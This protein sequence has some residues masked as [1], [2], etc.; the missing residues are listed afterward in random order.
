MAICRLILVI[1]CICTGCAVKLPPVAPDDA[2]GGRTLRLLAFDPAEAGALTHALVA[3]PPIAEH[4]IPKLAEPGCHP[5][6]LDATGGAPL[7]AAEVVAAWEAGLRDDDGP[8][9]WLLQPVV[10]ATEVSLGVADRVAGLETD[11]DALVVC[12]EQATPDWPSRLQHPALWPVVGDPGTSGARGG[13]AF[14]WSDDGRGLERATAEPRRNRVRRIVLDSASIDDDL[15]ASATGAFDLA[16]SW[17]RAAGRLLAGRDERLRLQRIPRWDT[18]YALWLVADRR[19]TN[20]PSFRRWVSTG[21]DRESMA[22]YLY[23]EQA[24]AA[25][26]LTDQDGET[27]ET[28]RRP[29]SAASSPRLT[30][31]FDEADAH[32][33][34]LAARVKAVLEQE[35]VDLRLEPCA[36]GDVRRALDE[37]RSQMV[38]LAHRPRVDDPVLAML[39]T[40]WPL[41]A[42][43]FEETRRLVRATRIGDPARRRERAAEIEAAMLGDARLVPLVRLHAWLARNTALSRV[44]VGARG[45]VRLDRAEWV[46]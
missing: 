20:D 10:G 43:A 30:L 8:H 17:G 33:A 4:A 35:N 37:G 11:G 22:S 12:I 45:V 36:G 34:N 29:F 6:P 31:V 16:F 5:V 38:L 44:E 7:S 13:G 3:A 26:G 39:D 27:P 14:R 46:R 25:Y 23:G 28:V 24:E 1:S 40:L 19:W 2:D 41:R 32:A 18:V 9:G 15:A 42:A 21:L